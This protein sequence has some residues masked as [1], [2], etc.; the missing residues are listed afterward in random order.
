MKFVEDTVLKED[1][2]LSG[3]EPAFKLSIMKVGRKMRE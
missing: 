1:V 3:E 2:I